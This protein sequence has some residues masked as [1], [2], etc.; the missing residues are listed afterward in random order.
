MEN[1]DASDEGND[2]L[3]ENNNKDGIKLDEDEES[4]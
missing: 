1:E 3:N 2:S 4:I